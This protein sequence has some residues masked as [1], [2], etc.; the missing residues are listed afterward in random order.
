MEIR[1][2]REVALS[3]QGAEEHSHM[4]RPDFRVGGHIFATL[5]HQETGYG[6]LM[7]SPEL[8]ALFIAQDKAV[9][10]PVPGGWGRKGA[11][12]ICLSASNETQL[13]ESLRAAWQLR[14]QK[15]LAAKSKRGTSRKR[16]KD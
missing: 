16:G 13:V 1:D 9:F 14:V 11:T 5:A 12:H 6:N 10:V 8:Q 7:L 3:F 15:S 2:F 4:G